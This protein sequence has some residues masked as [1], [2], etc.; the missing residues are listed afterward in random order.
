VHC[1]PEMKALLAMDAQVCSQ[2]AGTEP[3]GGEP[4]GGEPDGGLFIFMPMPIPMPKFLASEGATKRLKKD[5]AR[6]KAMKLEVFFM[7]KF[8]LNET[9]SNDGVSQIQYRH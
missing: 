8:C 5:T 4:V 7:V 3:V 1:G 9:G 6:R 2:V